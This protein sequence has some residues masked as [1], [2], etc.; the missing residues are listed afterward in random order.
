MEKSPGTKCCFDI[1][2]IANFETL[3]QNRKS[4][5]MAKSSPV[6]KPESIVK[7]ETASSGGRLK[8]SIFHAA[9]AT[10][11]FP[12][13]LSPSLIRSGEACGEFEVDGSVM[14]TLSCRAFLM[15]LFAGSSDVII[16]RISSFEA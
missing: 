6:H 5:P 1:S 10:F 16:F 14:N 9:R 8:P 3:L 11:P 12:F 15:T 7:S 2:S 4:V 13:S